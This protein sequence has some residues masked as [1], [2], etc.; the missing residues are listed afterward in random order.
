VGGTTPGGKAAANPSS[1]CGKANPATGSSGS[2][3]TVSGHQY[4]VKLPT[5]YD[6]SKPYPAM[7]MFNPT[8][9]PIS[10]AETSAGFEAA[11]PKEAWI[12]V[13]PHPANSS[14]GWGAGDVAF[15]QPFYDQITANFCIDKARVFASGESS[16]GDFASILGC[17]H[18]NKLRAV[19][20]CATK[21]VQQYQLN[22]TT[23]KCTGQVASI[24]IHGKMDS[25]VGTE[26]GP[27][28]RDFY[29]ALNHC[30][31]T[32]MPVMGYS[33][34]LSN[35]VMYQGCDAGYPVYW[36][37]HSDPNYSNTNHGWPAFAPKFLWALWSTY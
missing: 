3:L 34:S 35:C 16:G 33:D 10:W 11:G 30:T 25:V 27:K 28:T 26:N 22:A 13:Y 21:N 36:C 20:P 2:P 6:A 8:N 14:S 1:G 31:T 19:A 12:R 9:N 24:V 7:L 32:T 15:F 29:T 5:G 4:Y 17:E 18:A 23:R 37:S